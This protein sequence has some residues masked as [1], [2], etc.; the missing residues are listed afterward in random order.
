MPANTIITVRKG[1]ASQWTSS[2]PVL[3]SG[4]P[5]YDLSNNILKIG[6]GVSNWNNLKNVASISGLI[7]ASSGNFTQGLSINSTGVSLNGHSHTSS[8][9][10]DFNSSVSGLLPV[11]NIV[12]SGYASISNSSGNYTI[13]IT[14]VQP[15]GN[16]AN[17][18]HA[19]GYISS[20][21]NINSD[22]F[23]NIASNFHILTVNEDDN[24]KI[25]AVNSVKSHALW[26]NVNNHVI[27]EVG[28]AE[29]I[30][31][32]VEYVD[33]P[34]AFRESISAA[35]SIHSHGNITNSGTIGSTSGVLLSTTS[36]GLITTI[37]NSLTLGSTAVSIGGTYLSISG[38]TIDGGNI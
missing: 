6:D 27:M 23:Y 9:I 2:N 25:T 11:K 34:T 13:N 3:A 14:G 8:N 36:N 4:E 29:I 15:S 37:S 1:T 10:T 16:Y 31:P 26:D 18:I 24:N 32:N 19:H 7:T 12:G 33:Y 28:D 35:H 30:W 21:G 17:S 5:G 38:L 22:N 20:S